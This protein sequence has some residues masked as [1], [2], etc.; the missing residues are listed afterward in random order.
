MFLLSVHILCINKN[1]TF[2]KQNS[3]LLGHTNLFSKAAVDLNQ[4]Y[5]WTCSRGPPQTGVQ[6][7]PRRP[8]RPRQWASLLTAL[9]GSLPFLEQP[10]SHHP[11]FAQPFPGPGPPSALQPIETFCL[12]PAQ[13]RS[14]TTLFTQDMHAPC[15]SLGLY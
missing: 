1:F 2:N 3:T 13:L 11:A 9:P 10:S 4:K 7:S 6:L 14:Q 8:S 15:L 12:L 5:T